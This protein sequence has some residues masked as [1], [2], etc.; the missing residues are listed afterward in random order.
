MSAAVPLF[1]AD[2]F[3][4]HPLAVAALGPPAPLAAAA[5]AGLGFE[6]R[7]VNKVVRRAGG[8]VVKRAV[9]AVRGREPQEYPSSPQI[10][11]AMRKLCGDTRKDVEALRNRKHVVKIRRGG[12]SV[13]DEKNVCTDGLLEILDE[14]DRSV[15][16]HMKWMEDNPANSSSLNSKLA[17]GGGANDEAIQVDGL[18]ESSEDEYNDSESS[19]EDR[20]DEDRGDE[21]RGDEDRGDEDED[22]EDED[23]GDEDDEEQN[24]YENEMQAL[25]SFCIKIMAL[26]TD[27]VE[28]QGHCEDTEEPKATLMVMRFRASSWLKWLF[29]PERKDI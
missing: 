4:L 20:G 1:G 13:R 8:K 14:I 11:K 29:D 3:D 2:V 19:D 21:D 5:P 25:E 12:R 18:Q 24:S 16:F 10:M 26:C 9:E 23:S 22:D 6:W 28:A 17:L 15:S 27:G 7:D